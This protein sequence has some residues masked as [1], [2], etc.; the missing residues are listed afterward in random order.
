MTQTKQEIADEEDRIVAELIEED[1][2]K[3]VRDF[4]STEL[5]FEVFVGEKGH[6]LDPDTRHSLHLYE[7]VEGFLTV[8]DWYVD[9]DYQHT[10]EQMPADV[11]AEYV[12]D[13]LDELEEYS[14][15]EGEGL[16]RFTHVDDDY[17]DLRTDVESIVDDIR[18]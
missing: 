5:V 7:T 17:E 14:E 6:E 3:E 13:S 16:V 12:A 11:I 2:L 8:F 4:Q 1:D 10:D 18:N 15:I 9:E